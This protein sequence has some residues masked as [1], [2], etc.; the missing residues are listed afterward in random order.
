MELYVIEENKLIAA[1]VAALRKNPEK[2]YFG[3]MTQKEICEYNDVF[4]FRERNIG[5][6]SLNEPP[7]LDIYD[8]YDFGI[9]EILDVRDLS[10]E[11]ERVSFFIKKKILI[12]VSENSVPVLEGMKQDLL[13]G[14]YWKY[15]SEDKIAYL[16]FDRLTLGHF[17]MLERMEKEI[18]DLE[19]VIVEGSR[20]NITRDIVFF[21]KR[22]LYLKTYYEHLLDILETLAESENGLLE[23]RSLGLFRILEGRAERLNRSVQNLRDYVTQL[24][25]AYQAQVDISLNNT[26]KIFTVFTAIFLPLSLIAGWYGMNFQHMPEL[27][28]AYGYPFVI[29]L[30]LLVVVACLA[31]FKRKKFF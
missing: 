24:R 7:K 11:P 18:T 31:F 9:A 25:E 2:R 28:W 12:F 22:L 30:S 23:K 1:D 21:R 19:D 29:G 8:D 26:M 5:E 20:R 15:V 27:S 3:I 4:G 10:K 6:L 17:D 16:F 14:E 13:S